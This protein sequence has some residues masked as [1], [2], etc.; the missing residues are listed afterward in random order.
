MLFLG[1]A[2]KVAVNTP[3]A[4]VVSGGMKNTRQEKMVHRDI[5]KQ[6]IL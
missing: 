5:Q 4:R 6:I 2:G 3:P 1:N